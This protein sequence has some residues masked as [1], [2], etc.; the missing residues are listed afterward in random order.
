[1]TIKYLTAKIDYVFKRIF[2]DK[3]NVELLEAFLKAILKIHEDEYKKLT[4]VDPH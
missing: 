1:M 2:G 3:C 4:I